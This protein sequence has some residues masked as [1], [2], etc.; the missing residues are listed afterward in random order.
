MELISNFEHFGG[1]SICV[2]LISNCPTWASAFGR[3]K[4]IITRMNPKAMRV[5]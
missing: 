1:S 4:I 3:K 2:G 5:K